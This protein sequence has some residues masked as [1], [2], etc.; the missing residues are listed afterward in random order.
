MT[1]RKFRNEAQWVA[2]GGA[3]VII[4]GQWWSSVHYVDRSVWVDRTPPELTLLGF[5]L[6]LWTLV[7]GFLTLPR[8]QS[9]VALAACVWVTFMFWQGI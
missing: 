9:I 2:L 3:V 8:W 5:W 6:T 4:A 1:F 7:L